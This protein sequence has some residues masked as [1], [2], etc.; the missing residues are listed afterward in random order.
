[1]KYSSLIVFIIAAAATMMPSLSHAQDDEQAA[2]Y[3]SIDCMKSTAIDYVSVETDVW[4]AMHQELVDQGKRFSW[5]LY[6]VHFGDRSKCD[7]YTVTTMLGLE[8]LNVDPS[9]DKIFQQVHPDDDFMDVMVRTGAS[10]TR[11]ATELWVAVDGTQIKEHRFAVVNMMNTAD[12]DAYERMESQVFKPGHQALL[13][14]GHRSG[15]G[16]YAL[17]SPLGSSIPYNYSTVDFSMDLNPVPMA[18]AMM[19]ANPNRDLDAMQDLLNLR[20]QVSSQ[21][22]RL[23]AAT[24]PS[25]DEGGE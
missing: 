19:S 10:R 12:S 6:E 8:Q 4:Q 25:S 23:V 5:A 13:D 24:Q 9:Y 21:T 11:V 20:E 16:L 3:V 2:L 1:M 15:W 7:F 22:W 14:G 17:V 18:E